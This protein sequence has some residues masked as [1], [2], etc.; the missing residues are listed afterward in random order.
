[1]DELSPRER[2]VLE[3]RVLA[4]NPMTLEELA[5]EFG[6][7]RVRVRQLETRV[8]EKIAADLPN[9]ASD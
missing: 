8:R 3:A 7:A 9:K 6:V 5:E 4:D 1:M 2:R